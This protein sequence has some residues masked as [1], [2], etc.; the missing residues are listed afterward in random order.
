MLYITVCTFQ[1]LIDY[2][3]ILVIDVREYSFSLQS[4]ILDINF[5]FWQSHEF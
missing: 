5:S 4:I 3:Q 2:N 1:I